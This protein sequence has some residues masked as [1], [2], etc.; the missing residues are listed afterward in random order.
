MEL[1]DGKDGHLLFVDDKKLEAMRA[2][3]RLAV[4]LGTL[5]VAIFAV[6]VFRAIANIEGTL[7]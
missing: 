7:R 1:P 4:I 2:K 3:I 6:L 5:I